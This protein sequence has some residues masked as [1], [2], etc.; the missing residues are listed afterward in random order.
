MRQQKRKEIESSVQ[1]LLVKR[2]NHYLHRHSLI[3]KGALSCLKD[4]NV[5]NDFLQQRLSISAK[6]LETAVKATKSNAWAETGLEK[7]K[8]ATDLI[9][10]ASDLDIGAKSFLS[11]ALANQVKY[12]LNLSL[13]LHGVG[14]LGSITGT[15][16]EQ[17]AIN[18]LLC[19]AHTLSNDPNIENGIVN[20]M[21]DRAKVLNWLVQSKH[22]TNYADLWAIAIRSSVLT[23]SLLTDA[24]QYAPVREKLT[25]LLTTLSNHESTLNQ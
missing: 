25:E 6:S 16:A 14:V 4:Q 19:A 13:L 10:Q 2:F 11:D 21:M 7:V 9:L 3:A 15:G 12:D 18:C 17:R 8:H 20:I 22:L 1:G 23:L 24:K 5:D